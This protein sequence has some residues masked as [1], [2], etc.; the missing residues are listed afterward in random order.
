MSTGTG[1]FV[2]ARLFDRDRRS[3]V[4]LLLCKLGL[5]FHLRFERLDRQE[6]GLV[7]LF[8]VELTRRERSYGVE[9]REYAW[10]CWK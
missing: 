4:Y 2:S 8:V 7:L 6:E 1:S 9:K 3:I 5:V 10:A